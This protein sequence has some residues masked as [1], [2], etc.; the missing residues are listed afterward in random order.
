MRVSRRFAG[1]AVLAAVLLAGLTGCR[2]EVGKATSDA[3]DAGVSAAASAAQS[4]AAEALPNGVSTEMLKA[5]LPP[6]MQKNV[7]QQELEM[8]LHD[9][10]L[11]RTMNGGSCR[12]ASADPN[13]NTAWVS[14]V[15]FKPGVELKVTVQSKDDPDAEPV[16]GGMHIKTDQQGFGVLSFDCSVSKGTY[17]VTVT[18]ESIADGNASKKRPLEVG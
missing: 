7:T 5:V 4:H 3:A 8:A 15:G 6:A 14:V 13:T 17:V 10:I 11:V 1:S 12:S 9:G 18:G 16:L 2:D